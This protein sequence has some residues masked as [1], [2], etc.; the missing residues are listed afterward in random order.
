L[1]SLYFHKFQVP[2]K[3]FWK[4]KIN[5]VN[6]F[7]HLLTWVIFLFNSFSHSRI[8]NLW[9]RLH[10]HASGWLR[11]ICNFDLAADS[12]FHKL[13]K[14]FIFWIYSSNYFIRGS[15][16]DNNNSIQVI[17][18]NFWFKFS[19]ISSLPLILGKQISHLIISLLGR[20]QVSNF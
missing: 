20:K 13:C 19:A 17:H 10:Y 11:F 12:L 2:D 9:N 6:Y 7:F 4:W 1:R 14:W 8:F 18:L 15:I 5:Y 16:W 3:F